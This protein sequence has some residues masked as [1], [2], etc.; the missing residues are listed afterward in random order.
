MKIKNY[1]ALIFLIQCLSIH[2]QCKYR[3]LSIWQKKKINNTN[4]DFIQETNT[5]L[6]IELKNKINQL[7]FKLESKSIKIIVMKNLGGLH[8]LKHYLIK[9]IN[10]LHLQ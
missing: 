10:K 4:S 5:D 2:S 1:I 7:Y 9:P 8:N 3:G 6:I